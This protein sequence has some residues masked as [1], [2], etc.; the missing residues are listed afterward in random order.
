[1]ESVEKTVQD[2]PMRVGIGPKEHHP[3]LLQ[4]LD[5][6]F[7]WTLKQVDA[8]MEAEIM[9]FREGTDDVAVFIRPTYI[10]PAHLKWLAKAPIEF[11]VAGHEPRRLRTYEDRAAFR[12]LKAKVGDQEVP[13]GRGAK[14]TYEL[15]EEHVV[16]AIEDWHAGAY[17]KGKWVS[18]FSRLE[19]EERMKLRTGREVPAHWIRDQVIKRFKSAHRNPDDH[20]SGDTK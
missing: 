17:V 3:V 12:A 16:A 13:D 20:P 9:P 15:K 10:S 11:Q 18:D 8:L 14:P 6:E 7:A 19:I 1:M 4:A 2:G 5:C